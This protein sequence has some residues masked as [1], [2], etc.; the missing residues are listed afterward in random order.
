MFFLES[1][2]LFRSQ[3][4]IQRSY[5]RTISRQG[6]W[7]AVALVVAFAGQTR[8]R[9]LLAGLLVTFGVSDIV[10]THTGAWFRPWWM[11]LW[12]AVNLAGIVALAFR[13]IR[14]TRHAR[15]GRV[16]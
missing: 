8:S 5:L 1:N 6:V 10:E 14:A 2:R 3:C 7:I 4:S 15:K 13:E 11:L 9:W 16:N 12:K